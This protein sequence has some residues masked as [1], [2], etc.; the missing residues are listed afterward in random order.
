MTVVSDTN[1]LSSLA[2]A[3]ALAALQRLFVRSRIRVPPA[4]RDE[5]QA[6]I[7]RGR[8]YLA[9]VIDAIAA[10]DI[11]V[12]ALTDNERVLATALPQRLNAGECEAIALC[13]QRRIP[14]L[15]NDRRAVRYC[16]TN[17]IDVVDLPAIL[18][19]CW[20]RQIMTATDVVQIITRMEQ[21]E[22]LTLSDAQREAIFA[23]QRRRR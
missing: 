6:A 17:G 5:L 2:A 22:R 19:L 11:P 10:G 15:S 4:V 7:D 20:T 13:H 14:L 8:T 3:D 1:I 21:V 9:P 18:R 16:Q 12:L 23:P